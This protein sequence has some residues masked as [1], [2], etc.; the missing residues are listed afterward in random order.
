MKWQLCSLC[1]VQ[2]S[3]V[4]KVFECAHERQPRR[5]SSSKAGCGGARSARLHALNLLSAS[6]QTLQCMYVHTKS[7]F[8]REDTKTWITEVLLG[9]IKFLREL[10]FIFWLNSRIRI[11]ITRVIYVY[12]PALE[13]EIDEAKFNGMS[14]RSNWSPPNATG[15]ARSFSNTRNRFKLQCIQFRSC[16]CVQDYCQRSS[17]MTAITIQCD[18]IQ[19]NAP[20]ALQCKIHCN[21]VKCGTCFL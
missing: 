14:E 21:E 7:G 5:R 4:G 8:F 15:L 6:T 1:T 10:Y 13:P 19:L 2:W 12:H 9:N 3:V 16:S 17:N 11:V 18:G 20:N